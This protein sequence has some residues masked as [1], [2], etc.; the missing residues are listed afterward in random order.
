MAYRFQFM[1][2]TAAEWR[3]KN[4]VLLE[5]EMGIELDTDLFKIGDGEKPWNDLPYGG[6]MGPVGAKGEQ[7]EQGIPGETGP[8]GADGVDGA[9][10]PEG[11]Q[12]PQG[13]P[14]PA[15]ADGIQGIQGIQGETGPQ[16][17]QGLQG[18]QGI[19]GEQGIQ[20]P[21]G[22]Q[23]DQGYTGL[24]AYQVA[25]ANGY[26][27]TEQQWL[28]SLEGPMGPQGVSI[29]LIGSVPTPED[30]PTTG[31]EVNDAYIVDSDGDIWVWGES[32]SWYSAGQIVGAQGPQGIQ[33]ATGPAG[34]GVAPGGAA[35]QILAKIDGVDYNTEWIDNYT[36]SVKHIVKAGVALTKGQAVY[37][38][39]ADGT[40][41][42]VSK[43]SNATEATSSKTMGLVATSAAINDQIFVITEGLLAGLNTSTANAG[44]PVWLGTNG[45][46][47]YG[48]AN[49]PHAPAHLVYIGVV[50]RVQTNNGEIFVKVQN[51]Y[52]MDEL[53]NVAFTDLA[54]N[55]F[56]KLNSSGLWVNSNIIDGGTA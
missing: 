11:P 22:D 44:D 35:G 45:D 6:I 30:L 23:G 55:D 42:Y 9:V 39:S 19:Q 31:N 3:E 47:I 10:G 24:S 32:L 28:A 49:K 4:P 33:G 16:G 46:L 56:L 25:Q 37:V 54:A 8:A 43:A 14:G 1:R 51:G 27:G 15:G 20:G 5:A 38:S 48:L 17:E 18:I 21:K 36:S 2:G 41:M 50:T 13:E 29:H 52:E 26:S 34:E 40:N 12:G 53:H 7:G